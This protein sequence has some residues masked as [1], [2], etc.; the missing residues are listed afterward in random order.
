MSFRPG[1]R[2]SSGGGYAQSS[3]T[4]GKRLN[5]GY[6]PRLYL[7]A[8][9]Q[10]R[11]QQRHVEELQQE[12]YSGGTSSG[13]LLGEFSTAGGG[14]SSDTVVYH[15][16]LDSPLV[17]SGGPSSA[18]KKRRLGHEDDGG[19]R[20]HGKPK[21]HNVKHLFTQR[22]SFAQLLDE[23]GIAARSSHE[24]NYLTAVVKPSQFPPRKFCSVCGYFSNYTCVRCGMQYCSI[25]CRDTHNETRCLRFTA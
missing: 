14:S 20:H 9:A 25:S 21:R 15:P 11:A 13:T 2:S 19:G 3:R 6:Q 16:L 7:D 4:T 10:R 22:K 18:S 8:A 23:S 5:S 1:E 12:D 17:D 24:P